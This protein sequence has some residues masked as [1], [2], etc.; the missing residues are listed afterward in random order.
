MSDATSL[1]AAID[2]C[3]Y[4]LCDLG[5]VMWSN[6]QAVNFIKA[7]ILLT[8]LSYFFFCTFPLGSL[9]N[10]KMQ[11]LEPFLSDQLFKTENRDF[12]VLY[13]KETNSLGNCSVLYG[14]LHTFPPSLLAPHIFL[15]FLFSKSPRS[16][17]F[18]QARDQIS[19]LQK[20]GEIVVLR[21]I[22][23]IFLDSELED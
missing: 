22:I 21:M 9:E 20:R 8:L 19:H 18:L 11:N 16:W 3:N 2:C 13:W 14:K 12:Q 15:C 7:N 6:R 23:L 10:P 5:V 1:N 4:L 17:L